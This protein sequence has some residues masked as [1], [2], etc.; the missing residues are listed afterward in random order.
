M[1]IRQLSTRDAKTQKLT[2][3]GYCNLQQKAHSSLRIR[4]LCLS[5]DKKKPYRIA[6]YA[7]C[8]G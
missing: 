4:V 5:Y 2:V 8:N 1:Q 6:V 7:L 3:I